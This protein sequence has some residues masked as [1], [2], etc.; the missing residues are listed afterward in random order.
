[1]GLRRARRWMVVLYLREGEN[2]RVTA[3]GST[4]EQALGRALERA[5]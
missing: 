5:S 2:N 3:E 4:F 1:M